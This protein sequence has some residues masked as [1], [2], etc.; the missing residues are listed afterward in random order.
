[1]LL[2]AQNNK[3]SAV[4]QGS[5]MCGIHACKHH[6]YTSVITLLAPHM[7]PLGANGA[8]VRYACCLPL[9][10]H[11]WEVISMP[12]EL[13]L[14]TDHVTLHTL[15]PNPRLIHSSLVPHDHKMHPVVQA[16]LSIINQ[17]RTYALI[18]TTYTHN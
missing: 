13:Y 15:P 3:L 8:L 11:H 10:D 9:P 2:F 18:V 5:S 1:M 7:F 6:L 17:L 4:M 14:L 12:V 16:H